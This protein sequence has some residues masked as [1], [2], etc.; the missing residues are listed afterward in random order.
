M[1][2]FFKGKEAKIERRKI[3]TIIRCECKKHKCDAFTNFED[4]LCDDCFYIRLKCK[5]AEMEYKLK[6][7]EK[8]RE[9]IMFSFPDMPRDI[10]LKLKPELDRMFGDK[11]DIMLMNREFNTI[12]TEDLQSFVDKLKENGLIK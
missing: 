7:K 9:I 1:I 10:I 8:K 6:E 12:S 2:K 11:V 5:E 3:R 4:H